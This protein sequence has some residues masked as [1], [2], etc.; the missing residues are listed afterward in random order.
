MTR[1]GEVVRALA[2]AGAVL[3]IGAACARPSAPSVARGKAVFGR[4]TPCHGDLGAGNAALGAPAIGG[5]PR[6]YVEQQLGNFRTGM[7]GYAPFDTAGIRMKSMSWTLED[8]SDVV[9]VAMYVATLPA[10]HAAPTLHGDAAAGQTS[11]AVC[12]GCHQADA[13]G[14]EA[15]HAPP[16]AGRSDWYLL[17]Q[18]HNFRSGWRGTNGADMWGTVMRPNAMPLDDAGMVNVLAYIATL[19]RHP[20][21]DTTTHAAR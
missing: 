8:S 20:T 1:H 4:C 5:L 15:T 16:L 13:S 2:A 14:N 9:S 11:F 12:A 19:G 17:R 6:W 18:L 3:L 10:P 7:R 21:Q